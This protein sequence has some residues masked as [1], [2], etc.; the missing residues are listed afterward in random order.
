MAAG[1]I[2]RAA[3]GGGGD[4]DL[5]AAASIIQA[6]AAGIGGGVDPLSATVRRIVPTNF[7]PGDVVR[8]DVLVDGTSVGVDVVVVA[9]PAPPPPVAAILNEASPPIMTT[10]AAVDA[11]LDA[12]AAIVQRAAAGG[13]GDADLDEVRAE[14]EAEEVRADAQREAIAQE[15]AARPPDDTGASD[16]TILSPRPPPLPHWSGFCCVGARPKSWPKGGKDDAGAFA[17]PLLGALLTS[18]AAA[19]GAWLGPDPR[20]A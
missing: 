11:D 7:S 9:P 16:D 18:W 20:N 12:A 2:Q 3:A 6:A 13:G 19:S 1:L 5:D 15:Q 14:S 10:P 8:T 4:A 17:T